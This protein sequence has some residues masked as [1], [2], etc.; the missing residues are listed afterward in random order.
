MSKSW[1]L[2]PSNPEK[3]IKIA[4]NAVKRAPLLIPIFNHCYPSSSLTRIESFAV[5]SI[6]LISL[7]A[8][9]SCS[10]TQT[11]RS[12]QN[13]RSFNE[14]SVESS[15]NFSRRSLDAVTAG[16]TPRWVEFWSDTAV[17]RRR[18]N[19]NS[20]SSSSS[21]PERY[22]DMPRSEMPKWINE[23]IDQIGSV[24]R[25]GGW[26][27]SDVSEIVH[28][29]ASGFFKG[30]IVLLTLTQSS[31]TSSISALSSLF[32]TGPTPGLVRTSSWLTHS[33]MPVK[34]E[35]FSNFSGVLSPGEAGK[36]EKFKISLEM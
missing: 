20:S 30:E 19:S 34:S 8:S 5:V 21:S 17:D 32:H 14:K 15:F 31:T 25:E 18:R 33:N 6:S 3:A 26:D 9:L 12:Y 36:V 24:L 2:R 7:I 13:K 16:R 28:V 35:K 1:G 10:T 4:R 22:F 29:L 11:L 27:K 23:Y